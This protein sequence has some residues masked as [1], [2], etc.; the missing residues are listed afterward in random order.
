MVVLSGDF[1]V[2]FSD[3]D[4][5]KLVDDGFGYVDGVEFDLVDFVDDVLRIE[6]NWGRML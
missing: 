5:E 6:Y 3:C 4:F 1:E 2:F